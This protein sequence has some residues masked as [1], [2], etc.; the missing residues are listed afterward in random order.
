MNEHIGERGETRRQLA[1]RKSAATMATTMVNGVS[2]LERRI[3]KLSKHNDR[4]ISWEHL[5]GL[6]FQGTALE[7]S[8]AYQDHHIMPSRLTKLL[9]TPERHRGWRSVEGAYSLTALQI[10][11]SKV[12][13]WVHKV[14]VKFHGT[15][16]ELATK[17]KRHPNKLYAAVK[18]GSSWMG[19]KAII[20]EKTQ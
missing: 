12:Y 14:G 4:A 6:K 15:C 17:M 13:S 2:L 5:S 8:R 20:A 19:W 7:L 1:T 10:R 16:Y 3:H 11:Y 9:G 18:R